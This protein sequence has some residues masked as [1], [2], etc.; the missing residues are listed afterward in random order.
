MY[1]TKAVLYE[2]TA[3]C[4]DPSK[5]SKLSEAAFHDIRVNSRLAAKV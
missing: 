3:E 4:T 5:E 1:E 2:C